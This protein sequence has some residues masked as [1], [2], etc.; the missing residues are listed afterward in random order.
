MRFIVR[1][2]I[3]ARTQ[4]CNT[5]GRLEL[6]HSAAW[7]GQDEPALVRPMTFGCSTPDEKRARL[8]LA[9][10]PAGQRRRVFIMHHQFVVSSVG[11]VC[12]TLLLSG[13]AHAELSAAVFGG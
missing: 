12:L 13:S 10:I 5:F 2:S 11:T 8:E 9:T 1:R 3:R 7:V 6:G 4:R